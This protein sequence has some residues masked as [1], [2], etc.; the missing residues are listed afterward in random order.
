MLEARA[1]Q[2]IPSSNVRRIGNANAISTSSAPR[3]P[4][5]LKSQK[6]PTR[7]G[8][9]IWIHLLPRKPSPPVHRAVALPKPW[10]SRH[11]LTKFGQDRERRLYTFNS[12]AKLLNFGGF[13][14]AQ[15]SSRACQVLDLLRDESHDT[16]T[17]GVHR[18]GI[19]AEN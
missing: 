7:L 6:E 12:F 10:P 14:V 5:R 18:H 2:I 9:L 15:K 8:V 16:A 1:N 11:Q 17:G 19:V 13:H 3:S 4:R